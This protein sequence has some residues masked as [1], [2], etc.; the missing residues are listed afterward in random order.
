MVVVL[1]QIFG[2]DP[3]AVSAALEVAIDTERDPTVL[4]MA[5]AVRAAA[6]S[7]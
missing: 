4:A 1:G 6:A 3:D 7:A 2:R 5:R